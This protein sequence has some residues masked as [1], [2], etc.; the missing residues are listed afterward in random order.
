MFSAFNNKT[1][2]MSKLRSLR[3]ILSAHEAHMPGLSTWQ[4]LPNHGLSYLD[5]FILLN[6]HGPERFP[7]HNDGLPFGPHPHR[8]FETLTFVFKGDIVHQDSTG[9]KNT[10]EPG[11]VQWMTAGKGIIHSE[12]SSQRF[13]E[14]GGDEEVL[15]LWMN[16]PRALKMTEPA[17]F[18]YSA[19]DLTRVEMDHG[20]IQ[21]QLISGSLAQKKGPH[22]SLTDLCLSYADL[23]AG[24]QFDLPVPDGHCIFL[25]VVSGLLTIEGQ[26]AAAYHLVEFEAEGTQLR[27]SA[28]C[29]SRILFGHGAPLREPK[30]AQGP[31][32]MNTVGEIKQ[33]FLDY[34]AGKFA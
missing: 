6:H 24:A 23:A 31:F 34:Q 3:A 12:V 1:Q 30:V 19:D 14:E 4:A 9:H 2:Y 26:E 17:Y 33:A 21:L 18:G 11:G 5:P 13:K 7:P 15:Q 32:V 8:G 16:L 10:T 20:R 28:E 29:D 22:K 27:F 25:Y